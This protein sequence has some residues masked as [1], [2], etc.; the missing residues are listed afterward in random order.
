MRK[1]ID[2][3]E[4]GRKLKLALWTA[5]TA[6]MLSLTSCSN[7]QSDYQSGASADEIAK[8]DA[9]IKSLK[10]TARTYRMDIEHRQKNVLEMLAD[11]ATVNDNLVWI[12]RERERIQELK[13]ALQET[14][15][16]IDDAWDKKIELQKRYQEWK[17]ASES[18]AAVWNGGALTPPRN[19]SFHETE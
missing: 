11:S 6:L 18:D 7:A 13:D 14:E 19:R 5:A 8:I 16:Q 9:Q 10:E 12:K 17:V 15:E 4:T 1:S 3:K 2:Y